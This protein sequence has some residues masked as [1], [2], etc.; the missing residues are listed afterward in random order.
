MTCGKEAGSMAQRLTVLVSV[1]SITFVVAAAALAGFTEQAEFGTGGTIS[2]AWGDFDLDDLL[3]LAVANYNQQNK[4]YVNNGDTT[5][6][7]R[8][9][10]G[11]GATFAVVWIDFDNDGDSDL[12]VGNNRLE[13]NYIYINNGDGTFTQGPTLGRKRT[14][15]LAWGDVD[16][17]GDIDCAVG[18][19]LQG[20]ADGNRLFVNN[21]DGTFTSQAEFG[22]GQ[23]ASMVW[24]DFDNDGD[25]DMAVGNGGFGYVEQNYLYIN[26]L[27][28]ADTSFTERAEFGTGDT[29]CLAWGDYDNDGDLDMAVANWN[30]GQNYLYVNNGDGTFT[31]Q[32]QFG[33]RD[34]NTMAWGDYDNDGDL[35]LAVGNGDFGS[36]DTN[37]VYINN[38]DG[39]FTEQAEFG[40]GSTDAVAW[41]D[42]DRDGDLDLAAGNE[43]SPPQNYLYINDE[44]DTDYLSF[45]LVGHYHDQGSGYSNRDGI[46]AKVAIYEAGHVGD[47]SYLLGYREIEAHGG[48]SAQSEIS[49]HFGVPGLSQVDVRIT[50]PGSGGS[51]IVQDIDG[52]SVGQRLAIDEG[53]SASVEGDQTILG[54]RLSEGYPNPF[55][56]STHMA[57]DLVERQRLNL[58]IYDVSGRLVTPIVSRMVDQGRHVITWDGTDRFGE[59]VPPGIYFCRCETDRSVATQKVVRVK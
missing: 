3:D 6:T 17:D 40:L 35:D 28:S 15:A 13:L 57:L 53:P 10:F 50:W 56:G 34:P 26:N 27:E 41:G 25:I 31:Q 29:S 42:F 12:A 55:T 7:E 45:L 18:N 11:T 36:A 39:T 20:S 2:V 54:F 37:F 5:F 59:S 44:N 19:G 14:N 43:H 49:A 23:S 21:G 16:N 46:G 32:A 1:G 33:Q 48:F 51:N 30:G 22:V 38:S 4:L 8:D 52:V 9:E 24:G 58:A 47:N